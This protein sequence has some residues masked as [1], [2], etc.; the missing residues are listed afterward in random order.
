[1]HANTGAYCVALCERYAEEGTPG[2]GRRRPGRLRRGRLRRGRPATGKAATGKAPTGKAP[3]GKA[4]DRKGR[5]QDGSDG[6][7]ATSDG[8]Q[9]AITPLRI[10][11]DNVGRL[12]GTATSTTQS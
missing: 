9:D 10:T 8:K 4:G 1:M 11:Q 2:Q 6:K 3:T 12:E 7:A 5:D